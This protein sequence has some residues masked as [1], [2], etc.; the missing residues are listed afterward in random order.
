MEVWKMTIF[1]Y[2]EVHG[3]NIDIDVADNEIDICTCFC[4]DKDSEIDTDFQNMADFIILLMKKTEIEVIN[5][6]IMIGKFSD[7]IHKNEKLIKDFCK[8][9]WRKE[10]HYLLTEKN[11]CG[12]FEYN[13]INCFFA[14]V[15]GNYGNETA[16][17]YLNLLKECK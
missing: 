15:S 4:F 16:G 5:G 17:K 8:K 11:T 1:D 2:Y 14:C 10:Y 3:H 13:V 9:Q 6:D 7:I 12:D